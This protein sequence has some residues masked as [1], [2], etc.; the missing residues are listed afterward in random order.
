MMD[1]IPTI[2]NRSEFQKRVLDSDLPVVATFYAQWCEDSAQLSGQLEQMADE[3]GDRM[4]FVKVDIDQSGDLE[5]I[6]KI[7]VT[8]TVLLIE[9]GEITQRWE[10]DQES[11]D[12]R[13]A[14]DATLSRHAA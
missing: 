8:P 6:F 2:R 10:N 5:Q 1:N 14:F 4:K 11:R 7:Y 12:Y 13:G 3:Y 9:S